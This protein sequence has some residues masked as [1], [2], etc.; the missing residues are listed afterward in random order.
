YLRSQAKIPEL[1]NVIVA[2]GSQI[3]MAETLRQA[4]I[5]IFGSALA[6]ALPLDRLQNTATSVVPSTVGTPA[7]GTPVEQAPAAPTIESLVAQAVTH[8]D[9]AIKA[10]QSGDW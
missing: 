3:V 9:K 1:K 2:Y 6:T 7:V 8:Y 5:Q 10:Q 4:L